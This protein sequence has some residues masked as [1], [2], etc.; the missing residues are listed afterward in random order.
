[1]TLGLTDAVGT[2]AEVLAR[3][4][5]ALRRLDFA[6][7]TALV[8]AKEA[9]LRNVTKNPAPMR[10]AGRDPALAA[11]GSRVNQLVADNRKLLE[12]AI[13][14]QTRVVGIVARAASPSP[15]AAQYAASGFK[16]QT[17]RTSA[18]ALSARA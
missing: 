8:P 16:S 10:A 18:V 1:M 7:A 3:E 13:A 4:N 2:L 9:A 17:R 14:V 5:E 11:L 12:R 6:A 15:R